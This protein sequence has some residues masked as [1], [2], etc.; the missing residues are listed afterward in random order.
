MKLISKLSEITGNKDFIVTIGNF[1]GLHLGHRRLLKE[2][3]KASN[4]LAG[5]LVLITFFPHPQEFFSKLN[6]FYLNSFEEKREILQGFGIKYLLEI[7]FD[8]RLSNLSPEDFLNEYILN[9]NRVKKLYLGHDFSFGKSKTGNLE[10]VKKYLAN[11]QVELEVFPEFVLGADKVSSSIIRD[12]IRQGKIDKANNLLG[13]EF[14]IKGKVVK[15]MGRGSTI[16]VPTINLKI[17]PKRIVPSKGVYF[18]KT[19]FQGKSFDSITNVGINPTFGDN[20]EI[21]VETHILGFS[22]QIY[23]EEITLTFLHKL[24]EE[25]KFTDFNELKIQIKADIKER[26]NFR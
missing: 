12:L 26:V 20:G 1:D 23:G 13:R 9:D 7:T 4:S 15:G 24:R 21:K 5:D 8:E 3:L 2:A 16:D 17:D 11:S 6:D 25:R 10:F 19:N 18:T 22:Q 14:F